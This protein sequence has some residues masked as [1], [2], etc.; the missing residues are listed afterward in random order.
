MR[1]GLNL[2]YLVEGA[3]GLGT[4]ARELIPAMLALEPELRLTAFASRELPARDRESDWGREV[5]WVELPVTVTHGPQWNFANTAG[6]QWAA[7]PLLARRRRLDLVHGLANTAP[8]IGV[9]S[10]VTVLDLIW[11]RFPETLS[12]RATL[13]MKATTPPSARRANRVIA[14]SHA[15]KRDIVANLGVPEDRIDVTPLGF[16]LDLSVVPTP[17]ADLRAALALGD[18]RVVLCVA[19][20][21]EHKNLLNLIRAIVDVPEAILVLPGAPTPHEAELRALAERLGAAVRFPGWMSEADLEGL[22]R[23]AHAFVL[24]SFDEGFGLPV[25]EA[26]GRGVPVACS[27]AASLPE[28]AGEAALLFDPH[29]PVAMG[30][31]IARLVRNDELREE[32]VLRGHARTDVFPWRRT[33]KLTLESYR[34]CMSG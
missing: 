27:D 13:G 5:E 31:T 17:E 25:L 20:K 2:L 33:A 30:R 6:A 1:V 3:G 22:Y 4:Y 34:R 7:M 8:L 16:R 32:M 11:L 9:P 15:V 21:R 26:M 12:R 19:Q 10:V 14:I 23:L 29:D 24:P 28:V 18:S